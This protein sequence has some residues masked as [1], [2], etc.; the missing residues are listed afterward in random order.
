MAAYAFTFDAGMNIFAA[1]GVHGIW[2][3]QNAL[4]LSTSFDMQSDLFPPVASMALNF[5]EKFF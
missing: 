2:H 1:R 3:K 5:K 4:W